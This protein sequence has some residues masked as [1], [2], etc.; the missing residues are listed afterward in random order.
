MPIANTTPAC[1]GTAQSHSLRGLWR[2]FGSRMPHL[3]ALA[4]NVYSQPIS[5]STVKQLF[6]IDDG[7]MGPKRNKLSFA[8]QIPN[9]T[10]VPVSDFGAGTRIFAY[11]RVPTKIVVVRVPKPFFMPHHTTKLKL[12]LPG[13]KGTEIHWRTSLTLSVRI[14]EVWMKITKRSV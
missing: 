4:L 14:S 7:I 3:Q 13:Y 12:T 6:S 10:C 9:A 5:Q 11:L 2:L 8:T 1:D